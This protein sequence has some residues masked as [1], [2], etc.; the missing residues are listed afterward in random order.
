[1]TQPIEPV[2][3]RH[4]RTLTLHDTEEEVQLADGDAWAEALCTVESAT[5]ALEAARQEGRREGLELYRRM[6]NCAAGYSNFVDD[7]ASTR[8]LDKEFEQID[9][10]ARTLIEK[11][12]P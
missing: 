1:M 10:E 12:K 4:N 11:E 3:W 5:A 6:K 2:A 8:R 9:A 7:N